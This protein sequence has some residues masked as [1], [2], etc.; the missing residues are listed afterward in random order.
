MPY[1][2]KKEDDGYLLQENGGK[3]LLS[4]N[5][6]SENVSDSQTVSSSLV[7]AVY[8]NLSTV[9]AA[10]STIIA[11]KFF[12]KQ[13][14]DASS[15][16]DVDQDSFNGGG[17]GTSYFGSTT[18]GGANGQP[19]ATNFFSILVG[20]LFINNIT[21]SSTLS[22][23]LSA[24]RAFS[25]SITAT[26]ALIK[27]RT[28]TKTVSDA[29]T[30]NSTVSKVLTAVRT[31]VDSMTAVSSMTQFILRTVSKT[32]TLIYNIF[33]FVLGHRSKTA[34]MR[35]EAERPEIFGTIIDVP[36]TMSAKPQNSEILG[37]VGDTPV[38]LQVDGDKPTIMSARTE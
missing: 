37:T 10:V 25:E 18:M 33:E 8:K 14:A 16:T 11:G 1:Y 20:K 30:A 35:Q 12:Q 26:E 9:I 19:A 2:I 32:L 21:A 29:I 7:K 22:R 31:L 28:R 23:I 15:V 6:F 38:T 4:P 24:I 27:L 13:V 5:S 17:F 34:F 3:L 36:S